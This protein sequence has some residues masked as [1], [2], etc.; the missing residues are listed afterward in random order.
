MGPVGFDPTTNR[1]LRN[2]MSRS[3]LAN[4][5]YQAELRA[6]LILLLVLFLG[7]FVIF[8]LRMFPQSLIRSIT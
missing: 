1:Y 4:S 3:L 6:P 8:I 7:L 2:Y 5:F